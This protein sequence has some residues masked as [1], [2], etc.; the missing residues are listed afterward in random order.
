[1]D[2][3]GSVNEV[4][5]ILA[6]YNTTTSD[7]DTRHCTYMLDIMLGGKCNSVTMSQ[8]VPL[9]HPQ[10]GSTT[11]TPTPT[12]AGCN[13]QVPPQPTISQPPA[14]QIPPLPPTL[15]QRKDEME[16]RQSSRTNMAPYL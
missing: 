15:T 4:T 7:A 12:C 2:L 10:W 3:N 8:F 6:I 5:S 13:R 14:P 1:M 9:T 16:H 11:S